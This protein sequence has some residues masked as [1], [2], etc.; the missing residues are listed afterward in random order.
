[1]KEFLPTKLIP[2]TK[3]YIWGGSGLKKDWNKSAPTETIAECWEFSLYPGNE[4]VAA[5]GIFAGLKLS[6]IME[7]YPRAFGTKVAKFPIFPFLIKLIG[8]EDDLSIQVHP[9]DE[10][11]LKHENSLGKTEMWYIADAKQGASIYY[12]F[13]RDVSRTEVEQAIKENRI[14]ELLNRVPVKKGDSFFVPSGTVHALLAGVTVIEIQ[15]N[16]NLTYRVYDYARKDKS[17]K[18]RELHIDKALEVLNFGYSSPLPTAAAESACGEYSV[19]RLASVPYF[20]TDEIS[21]GG[22]FPVELTDTFASFTVAEGSGNLDDGR[23]LRKGD[24]Y[25]LP[26]GTRTTILGQSL[27]IIFTKL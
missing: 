5:D 4:S 27:K 20:T 22:A 14:T 15:E 7:K 18:E 10:Y 11:A 21:I 23:E 8:A 1:M 17:G 2:A 24:T 26:A 25:F 9:S 6:E 12:G 16:S 19:R 3:E 13:C